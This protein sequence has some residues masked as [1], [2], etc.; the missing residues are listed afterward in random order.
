VSVRR[1]TRAM[2]AG[3]VDLLAPTNGSRHT[4]TAPAGAGTL[5]LALATSAELE[6]RMGDWQAAY[7]SAVESLR[8][9][10]L[11]G[12][13]E[14]TMHGLGSLALVEAGLGRHE[15]C[16]RHGERALALAGRHADGSCVALALGALGLL[17]LGLGRFDPCIAWLERLGNGSAPAAA[18]CTTDLAEALIRRGDG[19]RAAD[20]LGA[21]ANDLAH[22]RAFPVRR[23]I[24][25][26]RGM[27]AA[28]EEFEAHFARALDCGL[29]LDEPFER[30]RTLLCLGQRLRR[31]DRPAAAGERLR[32][33]L[34]TFERLGAGPWIETARR[35]LGDLPR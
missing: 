5:T 27:L 31:A 20:A 16:R 12:S 3:T 26:C 9:A 15:A 30:A 22:T 13:C 21:L 1:V 32:A 24:E 28:D 6:F 17:E 19:D 33:A 29:H 10:E 2:D 18:S 25:R 23:A 14:E 35:E 4:L 8:M 7:A 34:G 11:T